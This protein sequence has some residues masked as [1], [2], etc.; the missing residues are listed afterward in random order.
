MQYTLEDVVAGEGRTVPRFEHAASFLVSDVPSQHFSK[1]GVDINLSN[2][3]SG[4]GG[5][6][7][8]GPDLTANVDHAVV[9]IKIV[10]MQSGC[11]APSHSCSCQQCEENRVLAFG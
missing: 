8:S 9:Q 2:A 3:L 7:C 1:A 11:L 4:F 10:D 6:F 5:Y